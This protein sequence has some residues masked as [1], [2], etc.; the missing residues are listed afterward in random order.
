[1]DRD[2]TG[3]YGG[4]LVMVSESAIWSAYGSGQLERM[5]TGRVEFQGVHVGTNTLTG[6]LFYGVPGWDT[7]FRLQDGSIEE[8]CKD[9]AN[10]HGMDQPA[11]GSGLPDVLYVCDPDL[12]GAGTGA[13]YRISVHGNA[14]RWV[15]DPAVRGVMSVAFAPPGPFG[16]GNLYALDVLEERVLRIGP[17]GAITVFAEGFENLYGPDALGFGPD[18]D[19]Y[20][21]DPA[22]SVNKTNGKG[23]AAEPRLLRFRAE[24][25]T[26]AP[27]SPAGRTVLSARPNPFNPRT[28]LA[29]EIASRQRVK[30]S[31]YDV[32]GRHVVDL[33]D[34][35]L[36]AGRHQRTWTGTDARGHELASGVY[37]VRLQTQDEL[38]T[39]KVT[40]VR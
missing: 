16:A 21:L 1:M 7:I 35:A 40:L 37:F 19:L 20:V 26:S 38:L 31:I 13:I 33:E 10:P 36:D 2:E 6:Q 29:F 25:V 28:T 17:T 32:A 9:L 27:D 15:D 4:V 34:R 8:W 23:S 18:G 30:L 5:E 3:E 39:Q 12:G 24:S 14:T 11:A 22:S